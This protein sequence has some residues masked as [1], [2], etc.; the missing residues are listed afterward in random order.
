MTSQYSALHD[1][2]VPVLRGLTDD[3]VRAHHVAL[4]LSREFTLAPK[5]VGNIWVKYK[6]EPAFH[7]RPWVCG[8]TPEDSREAHYRTWAEAMHRATNKQYRLD[9]VAEE[10]RTF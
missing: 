9:E 2:I 3:G 8:P 6:P 10:G 1:L 4:K 7:G 5:L